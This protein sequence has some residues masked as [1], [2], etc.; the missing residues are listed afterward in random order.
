MAKPAGRRS[1]Q[2]KE[3]ILAAAADVLAEGG[4]RALTHRAVATRAG[5]SL[6]ATTY[7]FASKQ[8]LVLETF[9]WAMAL[10]RDRYD[11]AAAKYPHGIRSIADLAEF[12]T[13][14]M[15][16]ELRTWRLAN[17]AWYEW[18]VEAARD[19]ALRAITA[20]SFRDMDDFWR[21]RTA[22]LAGAP[23]DAGQTLIDFL[24]GEYFLA[25]TVDP[26]EE[27]LAE[28]QARARQL[29]ETFSRHVA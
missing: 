17:L 25:L 4:P 13:T 15:A 2:R 24:V 28:G 5:V 16:D 11:R 3:K 23:G 10:A 20:A 14:G 29:I 21:G 9:E 18:L 6:S 19:P 1:A 7:Y 22:Q 12:T 27:A 8:D 26:P